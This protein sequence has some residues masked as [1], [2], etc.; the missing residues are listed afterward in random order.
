MESLLEESLLESLLEESSLEFL[1]ETV[2]DE[3]FCKERWSRI[4]PATD[5]TTP[6]ENPSVRNLG[7]VRIPI[8]NSS[9]DFTTDSNE[10]SNKG[11]PRARGE[12]SF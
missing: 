11:L 6:V 10:D 1:V 12:N 7:E 5:S 4:H 8:R 3:S 2:L 9:Q